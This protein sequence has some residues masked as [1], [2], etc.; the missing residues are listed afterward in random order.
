MNKETPK[1][2]I[3]SWFVYNPI[4]A[5]LLMLAIIAFGI[6]SLLNIRLESFPA[7]PSNTISINATFDG[8]NPE[9]VEEAVLLPIERALMGMQGIQSIEATARD[10]AATIRL[11]K[12]EGYDLPLLVQ[13]IK[14]RIDAID[15]FPE[16]VSNIIVAKEVEKNS[17]V[18]V[19]VQGDASEFALKSIASNVREALLQ[20]KHINQVSYR[21][22][23]DYQIN[24][25]IHENKLEQYS[26]TISDISRALQDYSIGV[27]IGQLNTDKGGINLRLQ[28][29]SKTTL[30]YADIPIR[31][32]NTG[33]RLYL[34]DVANIEYGFTEKGQLSLYEGKPAVM[35]KVDTQGQTDVIKAYKEVSTVVNTLSLALPSNVTLSLWNNRTR[36]VSDRLQFLSQSG[37]I[38]MLLVLLMLALF[39]DVKLA[40]WI[41]IGIPVSFAGAL[42]LMPL[43]AFNLS[44]NVVTLFAFIIVLGIIVDDAIVTGESIY[45]EKTRDNTAT[46]SN[47]SL[48][49]DTKKGSGESLSK[50]YSSTI[51]GVQKVN[52]PATFGV[53]TTVAA[54]LPLTSINSEIGQLLGQ[55]AWVV[56]FCLVFSLIESKIILPSHLRN[57]SLGV[58]NTPRFW[59]I[60]QYMAKSMLLWLE[61]TIYQRLI[62][63]A[64]MY[65]Y[66][67][68]LLFISILIISLSLVKSGA[69]KEVFFPELEQE[70]LQASFVINDSL[71]ADE[72][73]ALTKKIS[74]NLRTISND[75][76]T[77]QSLEYPPV[78]GI[79]SSR[80]GQRVVVSAELE[81]VK[82]RDISGNDISHLWLKSI[83]GISGILSSRFKT[84]DFDITLRLYASN[85]ALLQKANLALEQYL[86]RYKPLYDIQASQE[87]NT[88]EFR[89]KLNAI[90]QSKGI[91]HELLSSQVRHAFHGLEVQRLQQG[92]E[93]V[94]VIVRLAKDKRKNIANLNN[95]K[96]RDDQGSE[97]LLSTIA[98]VIYDNSPPIIYRKERQRAAIIKANIDK[99]NYSPNQVLAHLEKDFLSDFRQQYPSIR[100]EFG[101]DVENDDIAIKSLVKA[102]L[103]SALL[104]YVLLAI[105]LKSYSQPLLIISIIP[106]GVI[107]IVFGHLFMGIPLSIL[108][109][110]G[111]LALSGVVINDSLILVTTIKENKQGTNAIKGIVMAS[112]ARFRAVILT[113]ITTFVGLV[114]I[115]FESSYQAQFLVPT[116]VSLG[117]GILF[118]TLITLVLIPTLYAIAIDVYVG[119]AAL[120]RNKTRKTLLKNDL[121]QGH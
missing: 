66:F 22:F 115:I 64:L 73:T 80:I 76:S 20:E 74:L 77:Q 89:V 57:I 11:K 17:V 25:Y 19:A 4:A 2:G 109:F 15:S 42:L 35:L 85:I 118:S 104:I 53:L 47:H 45:T 24:I 120:N 46:Q 12:K 72:M 40:F 100:I 119:W 39:L 111:F 8:A 105:P 14:T 91:S 95:L 31:T 67:T 70:F 101:G 33:N 29:T 84:Q 107:G 65:R 87:N 23:R 113:S 49:G 52:I 117:F 98:D 54:F 51:I 110:F 99:E 37:L 81:E 38:S 78:K 71:S 18:W 50:D 28:E 36:E 88:E 26:L 83:E 3:I 79:Y 55:I 56:I 48:G 32:S 96:I 102:F 92:E 13:N 1:N 112:S 86:F 60:P 94:K 106:F 27:S 69:V 21:G 121:T 114:P 10:E 16:D 59:R 93:E 97:F 9:E 34:R 58:H 6:L 7:F 90:G 108:S 75:L 116:A 30:D 68:L 41:A 43:E 63:Y 5:N 44:L 103:L 62:R 61:T 82:K